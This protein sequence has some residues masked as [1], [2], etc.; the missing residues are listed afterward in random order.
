MSRTTKQRS[1]YIPL[2]R[3]MAEEMLTH[4]VASFPWLMGAEVSEDPDEVD[5]MAEMLR[6]SLE[7]FRHRSENTAKRII[8]LL[9]DRADFG[10]K[11]DKRFGKKGK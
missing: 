11:P 5:D 2:A 6:S 10:P 8:V 1:L 7:A 3:G 9:Q 4:L